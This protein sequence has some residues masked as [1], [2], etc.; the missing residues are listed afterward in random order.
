VPVLA[1]AIRRSLEHKS[2]NFPGSCFFFE[3]QLRWRCASRAK[4]SREPG[5]MN[6]KEEEM[7]GLLTATEPVI[8]VSPPLH[9]KSF[10]H[11]ELEADS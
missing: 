10:G 5:A 11:I 2:L 8:S 7:E 1:A 9:S 4:L 6:K 3:S